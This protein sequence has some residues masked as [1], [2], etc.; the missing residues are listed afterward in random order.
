M[1]SDAYSPK[2]RTGPEF[3]D[4]D[5]ASSGTDA[6]RLALYDLRPS[7]IKL[8]LH[9]MNTNA[10]TTEIPF[11]ALIGL[12][13]GDNEHALAL[14][15]CATGKI[16]TRTLE[17]SPETVQAWLQT[18][19]QRFGA[20]PIALA[21]ETSK[22]PLIHLFLEM[23]WLT[24][25]PVHPATSTRIRKAFAPSGAKDDIPDAQVLLQLL[26]AHPDKLRALQTDDAPT[27][28]LAGL[29][30]MRRK[31]VD[32]RTQVSNELGSV[33]KDYFPQALEL[34]GEKRYSPMAL[35][36]LG[37]WSDLLSLKSARAAT[38]QSFYHR[39]NVRRPE[40]LRQRLER[41]VQAK[42]LTKDEVMVS[43]GRQRVRRLLELLK[44]LQKHIAQDEKLLQQ[45]FREHP[46]SHLF[47]DLPGAGDC[48]A[49][50]LLVAF[51]TDRTRYSCAADLH[52]YS[53][54]APVKEKSGGRVW[55]HWRWNAPTFLRQTFI[56]W[57]G[58]TV[59]YCPWAKNY[60]DQQKAK[61][62]NHW[63]ILRSL[64]FIW[65]R[66]L[67]KC[68]QTHTPYNE[69][70]YLEALRKRQSPLLKLNAQSA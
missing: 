14:L 40:V 12:D 41:I 36:F 54:V 47:R 42:A 37:R 2:H 10:N 25:F 32:Q 70:L 29:C 26:V 52:K 35:E 34:T 9:H 28:R 53:G 21:L 57:A 56:E 11:A 69:A 45:A 22:G 68:W 44:T 8:T 4:E 46:E 65:I 7:S 19:E 61:G 6:P 43:L 3:S 18:L 55:I 67:W 39:H 15:D 5:H 1:R 62:K 50:R 48:L 66:I 31:S 64:A 27:R 59:V 33:L 51:G 24:V 23:P 13:W 58:Q 49:P 20:R 60:Y 16:E 17:H 63:S 38:L 30:E